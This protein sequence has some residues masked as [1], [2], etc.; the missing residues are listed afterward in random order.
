MKLR[1]AVFASLFASTV[2]AG[3]PAIG[4]ATASGPFQL[5]GSRIWGNSTLF[6]GAKIETTDAS[7]ELKL[8]NGVKV[9]LAAGSSARIWKNRVELE[10]GVGQVTSS[11]SFP[12]TVGGMTVEGSRYRVGVTSEARIEV[13]AL[14]GNARVLGARGTLVG[15]V[16]AGRNLSF[17]MQQ[18]LTRTGC[19][20]YKNTGFILQVDDSPEVLQLTGGNLQ[21]NL[22]NH[23]QIVGVPTGANATINPASQVLSVSAVTLQSNG[24]CLTAA[25]ALTAQTTMPTATTPVTPGATAPAT[26]A[27]AAKSAPPVLK[28]AGMSTG[29]KVAIVGA[30]G[31]GGAGAAIALSGK[32][33]STSP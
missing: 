31:G 23:V 25:A 33:K 16:P 19:L 21:P 12:V 18:T 15:S 3:A 4:V 2:F 24:G 6:E 8:S 27:G 30:I 29:A 28:S 9:Q 10:R 20:L 26:T 11:N 13:A 1:S 7:S 22:G 32:K 5:E 17:A 14:T